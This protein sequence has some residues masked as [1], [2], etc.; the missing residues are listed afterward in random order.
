[1]PEYDVNIRA[2]VRATPVEPDAVADIPGWEIYDY[3]GPMD[4]GSER[5]EDDD[6]TATIRCDQG[7]R[8]T[9][10][11]PGA[12]IEEAKIAA[13]AIMMEGWVVEDVEL[14]VDA[15]IDVELAP[16]PAP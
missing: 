12:A 4:D 11:D 10:D 13:S 3:Q 7:V 6:E 15:G 1:M 14:W 5:S 16:S 9:A 8:V 2:I